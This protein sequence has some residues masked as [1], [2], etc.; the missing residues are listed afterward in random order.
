MAT[1]SSMSGSAEAAESALLRAVIADDVTELS[2]LLDSKSYDAS[3]FIVDGRPILAAA[4][5]VGVVERLLAAGA[6][7]DAREATTERTALMFM[8]SNAEVAAA[9]L[10]GGADVNAQGRRLTPLT[11]CVADSGDVYYSLFP[12]TQEQ[13]VASMAQYVRVARLLL[14]AGADVNAAPRGGDVAIAMAQSD[15]MIELLIAAGANVN[16]ANRDGV[17][18]LAQAHS[19]NG[20]RMLLR[21]GADPNVG[22]WKDRPL[23]TMN[24]TSVEYARVLVEAGADVNVLNY[25]GESALTNAETVELARYLIEEAHADVNLHGFDRRTP[26]MTAS[27][28]EIV[29]LLIQHG[30]AVRAR[31]RDGLT[32]LEYTNDIEKARLLIA[33]GAVVDGRPSA[34]DMTVP[35]YMKGAE[36][37]ELYGNAGVNCD[38]MLH[39]ESALAANSD[40]DDKF[41]AVRLLLKFGATGDSREMCGEPIPMYDGYTRTYD[42][43][44]DDNNDDDDGANDANEPRDNAE[45]SAFVAAAGIV[46]DWTPPPEHHYYESA[47]HVAITKK[48]TRVL[49]LLIAHGEHLTGLLNVGAGYE[50]FLMRRAG[51]NVED[52][53]ERAVNAAAC[54]MIDRF[55]IELIRERATTVCVA[56]A[57][58]GLPA[59]LSALILEYACAPYA[60]CVR[61]GAKWALVTAV[62]HFR[63]ERQ[64]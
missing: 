20:M 15:E 55:R 60:A 43:R 1:N 37:I 57:S 23:I 8:T 3:E 25:R 21:A 46:S 32:A 45:W 14:E 50:A 52:R 24:S 9:L 64:R 16:V 4:K 47:V 11:A 31:D 27:N 29:K 26:L 38:A 19:L 28:I 17:A 35:W 2:A 41:D 61:F 39:G 36:W 34:E 10:R 13:V 30:A 58:L 56:T 40:S 12:R 54:S 63:D 44:D 48:A 22:D 49:A 6:V 42:I 33:H 5:S 59:L 51:F 62:K 18:P 7:V 53:S